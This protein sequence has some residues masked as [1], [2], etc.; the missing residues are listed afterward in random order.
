MC[1]LKYSSE[2]LFCEIH[3]QKKS[4]LGAFSRVVFIQINWKLYHNSI[5][6]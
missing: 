2:M 1:Y 4:T 6:W 5:V 3:F